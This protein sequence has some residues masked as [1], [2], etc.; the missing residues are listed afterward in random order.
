MWCAP[1]AAP[2]RRAVIHALRVS[3]L[4]GVV[5]SFDRLIG[6]VTLMGGG[7]RIDN[8]SEVDVDLIIRAFRIK[9]SDEFTISYKDMGVE[10]GGANYLTCRV[11]KKNTS[12]NGKRFYECARFAKE[13]NPPPNLMGHDDAYSHPLKMPSLNKKIKRVVPQN[14]QDELSVYLIEY[15]EEKKNKQ[16]KAVAQAA[17]AAKK[18]ADNAELVAKRAARLKK[19]KATTKSTHSEIAS[20]G[21]A[22][23]QQKRGNPS[24]SSNF[25]SPLRT[26]KSNPSPQSNIPMHRHTSTV[27]DQNNKR[28]KDSRTQSSP[29]E[30]KLM[31]D[32][33][34]LRKKILDDSRKLV[35]MKQQVE[36]M[37]QKRIEERQNNNEPT[38]KA[39]HPTVPTGASFHYILSGLAGKINI[40]PSGMIF[41]EDLIKGL[42]G[43]PPGRD[44]EKSDALRASRH[45]STATYGATQCWMPT[46]TALVGRNY[47]SHLEEVILPSKQQRA[48]KWF[49]KDFLDRVLR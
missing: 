27:N 40:G 23:G 38:T 43:P 39:W 15:K 47:L 20:A 26:L 30:M 33:I 3:E 12:K 34:K 16:A 6:P 18:K 32:S 7:G 9:G 4:S 8:F 42:I 36:E 13:N 41:A 2:I 19:S 5:C 46:T 28:R 24:S 45:Y 1:K 49:S 10:D 17:N 11:G 22:E 29:E 37:K 35:A 14:V 25:I 44:D 31:T 48:S 21:M